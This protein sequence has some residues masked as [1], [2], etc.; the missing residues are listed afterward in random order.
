MLLGCA[1]LR[2]HSF[3]NC[4]SWPLLSDLQ[5]CITPA[6]RINCRFDSTSPRLV[7]RH[8]SLMLIVLECLI[9]L[10]IQKLESFLRL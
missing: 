4:N 9:D 10:F 8:K 7:S 3:S 2:S 5:R 1:Y 6:S